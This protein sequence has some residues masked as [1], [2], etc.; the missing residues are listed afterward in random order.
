MWLQE[1]RSC[2]EWSPEFAQIVNKEVTDLFFFFFCDWF[3]FK[4]TS[5]S[6]LPRISLQAATHQGFQP[7][8]SIPVFDKQ[9]TLCQSR[10]VAE[11]FSQVAK[12]Q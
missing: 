5:A 11:S 1:E 8:S 12:V 6:W 9:M 3:L 2:S 4:N 7:L 10:G